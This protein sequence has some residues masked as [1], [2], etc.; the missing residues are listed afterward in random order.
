MKYE[1][2]ALTFDQQIELLQSR[3]LIVDDIAV[4]A[5]Y[6]SN[7]SYYRLS[8]YM[9]PL[10][11]VGEDRFLDGTTFEDILR[12]YL[13]DREF[14]L[15]IFDTIEKVEVAF[16]TQMSYHISLSG[17]PYWFES[18]SYFDSASRW[19]AQLLKIDEE[20][21]R[22]KEVFKEHFFEKYDEHERMP[23]WMTTEV[24][25]LGLLSKIYRNLKMSPEKKKI[26]RHFGLITPFVLESWMQT[27]TYVRNICAH[28]SRLWN[29]TLTVRP[30]LLESPSG[31]WI[32]HPATNDKSYYLSCCLLYMMKA[33]NPKT[34]FS[35]HFRE[36]LNRYPQIPLAR[37][38]FPDRW[39]EQKFWQ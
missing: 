31:L 3:G 21:A 14:R 25:S 12:L 18:R 28:H 1:K 7:I 38:G 16:R 10:K 22:A 20:V 9:L 19:Q 24:L 26:A 13:F 32:T 37:M 30:Q 17:G 35:E 23:V 5:S 6:L 11:V 33:V 27:I 4:A 2:P 34:R 29:R 39:G 8:A 36:L 15:L